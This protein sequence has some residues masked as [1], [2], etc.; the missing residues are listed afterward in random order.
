M[1]GREKSGYCARNGHWTTAIMLAMAIV[2]CAAGGLLSAAEKTLRHLGY[3]HHGEPWHEYMEAR[4][5]DFEKLHPNVKIERILAGQSGQASMEDKF[6]VMVAGGI[7]PDVV[8][9]TLSQAGG[10]APKGVFMDLRPFFAKDTSIRVSDF[11]QVAINALT[12]TDGSQWGIP[13]DIYPAPAWC[14]LTLFAESG[15]PTARD[16]GVAGWTWEYAMEAFKKLTRDTGGDGKPDQWGIGDAW[17]L[18]SYGIAVKQAGGGLYDRYVDPTKAMM[19][20]PATLQGFEWVYD[21]YRQQLNAKDYEGSFEKGTAGITYTGPTWIGLLNTTADFDW[22]IAPPLRGPDNN[23]S[24]IAVNSIQ[25][26][27]YTREADIAWEWVKFLA[28]DRRNLEDF[29]RLTTRVPALNAMLPIYPRLI[30]KPPMGIGVIGDVVMNPKS[31]HPPLG[32][33]S[34]KVGD[35]VFRAFMNDIVRDGKGVRPI[36]EALTSQA[37]AIID[38]GRVGRK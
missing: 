17:K 4:I 38:E 36:M 15:L 25:M 32:P 26:S 11:A 34:T 3:V 8:E 29:V 21:I 1:K 10:M 18:I 9:M 24:Y 7:A 6:T 12:W 37:N 27:S 19:A 23:G 28:A 22:D 20:D 30:T 35:M 16:L 5:A 14:N 2:F 33:T 31:F 13:M